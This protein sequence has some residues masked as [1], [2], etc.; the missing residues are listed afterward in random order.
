MCR[1]GRAVRVL[2]EFGVAVVGGEENFVAFLEGE[3]DD[4]LQVFVEYGESFFDCLE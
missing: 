1:A 4:L 2:H 3:R